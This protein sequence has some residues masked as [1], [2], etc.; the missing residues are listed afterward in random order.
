MLDSRRRLSGLAAALCCLLLSCSDSGTGPEP[1]ATIDIAGAVRVIEVGASLQLSTA[2]LD[3][4]G[5]AV[6][7]TVAWTSSNQAAATVSP[8][9]L[10]A[11][12]A[13][14][15]ATITA[16]AGSA[17]ASVDLTIRDNAPLTA[18]L[19]GTIRR[20]DI[21]LE[22]DQTY[23]A[24]SDLVLW[25]DREIR[26]LGT[27]KADPGVA[28]SLVSDSAITIDGT[29]DNITSAPSNLSALSSTAVGRDLLFNAPIV[30]FG[31][32]P[33]MM[34]TEVTAAGHIVVAGGGP[35]FVGNRSFTIDGRG[36]RMRA[37]DGAPAMSA[38]EDGQ[39]GF[40]ILIGDAVALTAAAQVTGM[41]AFAFDDITVRPDPDDFFST[42]E[43]GR[44]GWG[45]TIPTMAQGAV[46]QGTIVIANATNGGKGGGV[47]MVARNSITIDAGSVAAGNGGVGG[48]LGLPFPSPIPLAIPDGNFD[49]FKAKSLT[50]RTG[51]GGDGGDVSISAPQ[52]NGTAL[53]G[54]GGSAGETF[55]SGGNAA[56]GGMG[57]EFEIAMG[58][59]G[60]FGAGGPSQ[61][62]NVPTPTVY[63]TGALN[64]GNA[65]SPLLLGGRGGR[66]HV[67]YTPPAPGITEVAVFG[68]SIE[69]TGNGG[70]GYQGCAVTPFTNGTDG[71]DGGSLS[72]PFGQIIGLTASFHGGPG[73]NGNPPGSGGASGKREETGTD[74]GFPGTNGKPCPQLVDAVVLGSTAGPNPAG[75]IVTLGRITGGSISN[76]DAGCSARHL[77]GTIFI[78]GMGPYG[79]PFPANCGHGSII[80]VPQPGPV[81]HDR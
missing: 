79:D 24:T 57:G 47:F 74:L 34:L 80:Q 50:A 17:T 5:R 59:H 6:S 46:D 62:A 19:S 43:A 66:L 28:L 12:L 3:A 10:V 18:E 44:G 71:G 11:G 42:I 13:E 51:N 69:D 45:W 9:G 26:V 29:I 65:N 64:G 76:P 52:V 55:V 35:G 61:N 39:Q 14:G 75:A 20:I 73:G 27:L 77:H 68:S 25:A 31:V 60:G 30:Q 7:A 58:R 8:N 70:A 72:T 2:T 32:M 37:G 78:D 4:E 49:L 16:S 63:V 23:T 40:S 38:Q 67:T 48:G 15:T 81:L 41:T 21:V 22:A 53:V 54:I 33:Q 56:P 36:A 1:V